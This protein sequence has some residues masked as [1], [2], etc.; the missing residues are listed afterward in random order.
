MGVSLGFRDMLLRRVHDI[1]GSISTLLSVKPFAMSD[2]SNTT[3][4]YIFIGGGT[5]GL[6][7][8]ARLAELS[9]TLSILV[10]EAGKNV[11][12]NPDTRIPGSYPQNLGNPEFDWA[13]SSTPQSHAGGRPVYLP[14]GKSLG[15]TSNLNFMQVNRANIEEYNTFADFGING[16]GWKD[17]L[18][19]FKKY[20]NL[21]ASQKSQDQAHVTVN[22]SVHGTDGPVDVT[23]PIEITAAQDYF[24]QAMNELGVPS[25]PDSSSGD[26]RG[27][28][29]STCAIDPTT[30]TRVSADTAYLKLNGSNLHIMTE[31]RVSRILF[32]T[33]QKGEV[34][35]DEVEFI[36]DGKV[37]RAKATKEVI[38]SAGAYQTPQILEL[39]GI[40]DPAILAKYGISSVVDLPTV[41]KNLQEHIYVSTT[42]ELKPSY[43]SWDVLRDPVVAAAEFQKYETDKT[44]KLTTVPFAFAFI[45]PDEL[46]DKQEVSDIKKKLG[47]SDSETPFT[48]KMSDIQKNWLS[49]VPFVEIMWIGYF[50]PSNVKAEPDA[51]KN[52]YS[53]AACLEHPLSQGTV[54]IQSANVTENPVIDPQFFAKDLDMDIILDGIKYCRKVAET[55]A[56]AE[57]TVGEVAPG[58]NIQ[59]NTDL[60]E[61]AKSN[62]SPVF[63]PIGTAA[64]LPKELGGVVDAHLRVYG[65]ANLRVVDASILPLHFTAHPMA[66]LYAI[67]EK[68]AEMIAKAA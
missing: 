26:N 49:S 29:T 50:M 11:S 67:A 60:R 43:T 22:S 21:T 23:Y 25:N 64:M 58:D 8:A 20:E 30:A 18:L 32:K 9:P 7:T 42:F 33:S 13:F 16:W 14:R 17:L 68:A 35:A 46:W 36:Q 37:V 56:L 24:F 15:G 53:L 61:Y 41:G 62:F 31:A 40:G 57:I 19:Y 63:H 59:S 52:Y 38:L 34:V 4:D 28:W 5:A 10:L 12:S 1:M 44:G 45:S 39:S 48:H 51:G 27:V 3:F 66:T 55:K 54:H 47:T 65:T 2:I 6:P